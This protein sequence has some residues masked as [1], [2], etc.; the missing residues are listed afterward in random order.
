MR[1][2]GV[3]IAQDQINISLVTQNDIVEE[4]QAEL[5]ESRSPSGPFFDFYPLFFGQSLWSR[6]QG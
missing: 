1:A 5:G 3:D 2:V 6:P 4:L